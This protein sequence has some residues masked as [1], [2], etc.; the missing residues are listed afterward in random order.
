M[1]DVL[2]SAETVQRGNRRFA[3]CAGKQEIHRRHCAIDAD[4]GVNR[5]MVDHGRGQGE[6]GCNAR[7]DARLHDKRQKAKNRAR[8]QKRHKR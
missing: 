6:T 1:E 8:A 5:R 4:A 7:P 2:K 3:V